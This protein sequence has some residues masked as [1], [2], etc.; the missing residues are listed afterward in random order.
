MFEVAVKGIQ[1]ST[2]GIR[3]KI[4]TFSSASANRLKKFLATLSR[5]QLP[6]F[7]TLT[8]PAAYPD[9]IQA[10]EH[11]FALVAWIRYH[12]VGSGVVWK[13]E[14]QD[15]GAPHFHIFVYGAPDLSAQDVAA[16]WSKVIGTDDQNVYKFHTGQLPGSQGGILGC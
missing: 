15:R 11:L 6:D 13:M 12:H 2:R 9:A 1:P 4:S 10:K 5:N 14:Y 16:H 3:G 7:L 8:Y